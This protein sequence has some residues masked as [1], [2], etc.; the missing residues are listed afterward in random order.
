MV[1][2]VVAHDVVTCLY[3]LSECVCE[4]TA[5]LQP[6]FVVCTVLRITSGLDGARVALAL[7]HYCAHTY[8][9]SS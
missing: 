3:T 9:D 2:W 4:H 5:M 1:A 8:I 7:W 6:F